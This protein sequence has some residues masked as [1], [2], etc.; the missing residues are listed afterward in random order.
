MEAN[1]G[2][3]QQRSAVTPSFHYN[4]WFCY[5]LCP[6]LLSCFLFF[7]FF[8]FS[9]ASD[10][11]CCGCSGT[12]KRS[13]SHTG[14]W[15]SRHLEGFKV[16]SQKKIA[17]LSQVLLNKI[18]IGL[19]IANFLAAPLGISMTKIISYLASKDMWKFWDM[20]RMKLWP[21]LITILQVS[22]LFAFKL[23]LL[24]SIIMGKSIQC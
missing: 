11:Q 1:G 13:L 16:R 6:K 5:P 7:C 2:L 9:I 15:I 14:V 18:Y 19:R 20:F 17:L 3:N 10:L 21:V 22:L 4:H 24:S 8:V 12:L 23:G